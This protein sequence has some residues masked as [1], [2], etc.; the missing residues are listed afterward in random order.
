MDYIQ[1]LHGKVKEVVF[2]TYVDSFKYAHCEYL[3]SL[4]SESQAQTIYYHVWKSDLLV[5]TCH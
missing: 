1:T 3:L 2:N 4:L 5:Q